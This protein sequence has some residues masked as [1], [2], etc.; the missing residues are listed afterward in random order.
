MKDLD[1]VYKD[2][3]FELQTD[4]V[5]ENPPFTKWAQ[6]EK[7]K[8]KVR[9]IVSRVKEDV[10]SYTKPRSI[11]KVLPKKNTEIKAYSP[12]KGLLDSDHLAVGVVTI[13]AEIYENPIR[14]NK[15][16]DDRASLEMLVIDAIENI[17][18]EKSFRK[19]ALEIKS[20]ATD[21]GLNTT[22][23]VPPGSGRVDWGIENQ[24][25][26]F[27]LINAGKIN[28]ELKKTNAISPQK[29]LSFVIGIG[30]EIKN[31]ENIFSCEGCER[32][33]CPYR[34]E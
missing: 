20:E 32:I 23:I 13:G 15:S 33:D 1:N 18:L 19:V 30:K 3:P 9:D 12:P 11:Q 21:N 5:L 2:I 4:E 17:A 6:N 28:V 14:K 8:M 24:E 26:I 25:F 16:R 29:S 7:T 10:L 22:R 27:N 34:V 31:I